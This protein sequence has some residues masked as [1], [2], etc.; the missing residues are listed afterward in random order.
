MD[1]HRIIAVS[2]FLACTTPALAA[3]DYL[4]SLGPGDL[5]HELART[6]EH[7]GCTMTED[8]MLA[9]LKTLGADIAM[10]QSII[11]DLARL[12]DL[13]WNGSDGYTLVGWGKC[14]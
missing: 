9:F 12:G 14:T 8:D 2:A 1:I 11:V 4:K 7:R 13:R 3:S 6:M 10:R 5:D